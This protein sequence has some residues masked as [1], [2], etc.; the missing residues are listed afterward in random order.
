MSYGSRIANEDE[1]AQGR[2][3]RF[4]SDDMSSRGVMPVPSSGMSMGTEGRQ[5][6][7]SVALPPSTSFWAQMK[8]GIMETFF[9]DD[10]FRQFK[11]YKGRQRWFI[12]L[13]YIFP[14][15]DWL[16][17]YEKKMLKGDVIA[18]LTIASL[19]IPQDLGYAKL[20]NLDPIHGLYA[21]FV[22]PLIYALLGSSRDI[23][24]GP[25]GVISIIMGQL[26]KSEI[27]PLEDKAGYLRLAFTATFFAGVVQASL[28]ILRLGF[29]IDFLS[30]AAIVGFMSGAAVTIALQQ[31]KG[32]LG[33][34]NFTSSSD[35]ISVMRSVWT[36]TGEWNWPTIALGFFF[37]ILLMATRR[38][39]Q[40][41]KNFF[42]FSAVA[43]LACVIVG[44]L[45]VFV[46]RLDKQ[47][48]KVI[49]YIEKGV[50][51]ASFSD[52]YWSGPLVVRG[53]KVGLVSGLVALT[54]AVAIGRTFAAM[55]AY[56]IDGN[57]EMLAIGTM[58]I[59][60]SW[61][62]CYVA[63]GSF[64]RSAVNC[65]SGC[66]TAMSNVV[67]AIAV[68]FTLL[69]LTPLFHYTPNCIL[70]AIIM[71]AVLGLMDLR[72]MYLVWKT[73]KVDFLVLAGA[74]FGVMFVSIEIGLLVAVIISFAKILIHVT[75][76][77]TALLGNIPGTSVYHD[78]KQY[79]LASSE[80]GI[81]I[82]RIDAAIYFSNSNYV[83]ERI[84][85]YVN[86]AED[87]L[88]ENGG[89]HLQFVIVEMAPVMS[90]DTAA[91][92]AFEELHT[93]L[94]KRGIQ[95]TISN[96]VGKVI[97]TFK[98]GGFV[99]LLGQEWFFLSVS[100]GVQVCSIL[101]KRNQ[102]ALKENYSDKV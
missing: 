76:P 34:R 67:M 48:I 20:A 100:E 44:T 40:M 53:F 46:T 58:N 23:A 75:R 57:K 84:L 73:D 33:I 39:S 1:T 43:P 89:T 101:I 25:V 74:F 86:D 30:H 71:N 5:M 6:V 97:T 7:H 94:Q 51:P 15:L 98:D 3:I 91:I 54:E 78:I 99:D 82:V 38:I 59:A 42:W 45:F 9:A 69:F 87:E 17:K 85:R 21:S 93:N 11:G 92:H 29:L 36:H 8:E 60:G 55:K 28:G 80:P 13:M 79:P 90:I 83:R 68:L 12:G 2:K 62:S 16:P 47:G 64:S 27:D 41:R 22:P 65:Q 72:A 102:Q 19:S 24:I 10:P 96:T 37:L 14:I 4:Q 49:G 95:L 61:T 66:Y 26:L 77:H 52:I 35:I 56:H 18:G 50:N 31:L 63:T 32:L 88:A 70:A 81:V